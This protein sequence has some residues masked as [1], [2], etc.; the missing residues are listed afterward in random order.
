MEE[1]WCGGRMNSTNPYM[2]RNN[3]TH[4]FDDKY[5]ALLIK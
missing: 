4:S 2:D 5:K 3:I 1:D